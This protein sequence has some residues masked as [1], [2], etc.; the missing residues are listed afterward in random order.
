MP[1]SNRP[2]R[3]KKPR[4]DFPLFPH[5][6]GRWAKKV[7]QRLVYFGKVADDPD[8]KKALEKWLDQRDDLLAGRTPR[9]AG[10][11]LTVMAL[12][13]TFLTAKREKVNGG[14]LSPRSFSDYYQT[15]E[16]VGN[17]F[18]LRRLVADL[19]GPDFGRLRAVLA[20]TH[21]P[22]ALGNAITRVRVLFGYAYK[23]DLIERPVKFGPDFTRPSKKTLRLARAAKGAR[24]FESADLRKLLDNAPQPL[25]AMILLALN[26]GLG[27][28]DCAGLPVKALDLKAGWLDFPRPKTGIPRRCPLW[29]ETVAAVKEALNTRPA[30]RDPA[31]NG[32]AFLTRFGRPWGS[33][34]MG[35]DSDGNPKVKVD[36]PLAK[37]FGKMVRE[38]GLWRPGLGFYALRHG[39]ETVA[40]DSKDQV[41]TDAIMGHARDDM[42]S[43]YRER[44]DDAR[45]RAVVAHVRKWLFPGTK[46]Q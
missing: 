13:N 28:S 38:L 32:L 24:M 35:E 43:L 30:P 18:G 42:A 9:I 15:C 8:G 36:D 22:V 33:A 20:K 29:P 11:G 40:G 44:L 34:V 7:K 3:P 27:N 25:R 21:G 17:V 19:N 6:T 4:P 14:E 37:E 23:A 1:K 5:A 26:C 16:Q 12:L 2:E 31:H 41:A 46:V 10:E 39:F 45:L